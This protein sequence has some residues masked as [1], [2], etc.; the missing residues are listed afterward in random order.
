MSDLKHIEHSV[1]AE[2]A[3]LARSLDALSE[4][5]NPSAVAHD[6]STAAVDYGSELAGKALHKLRDNPAGGV[7]VALGLGLMASGSAQRR[8]QPTPRMPTANAPE[9]ALVGMDERIAQADADMR[10]E[11][12]SQA[13]ASSLQQAL[14][15]GLDGLPPAA[16]KRVI[17]A[18]EAAIAA[19]RSVEK[20]SKRA[21]R[22]TKSFA[23]EQP[24]ALGALALG[25][26]VIAGSLLPGT[27]REDEVLGKRRDALVAAARSTLEEEMA[28]ARDNAEELIER[29][30]A[31]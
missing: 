10:A 29:K 5:V 30:T 16:K 28:K 26:G 4:T 7:L 25:F 24:L 1:E 3:Q 13:D 17:K 14:Q 6:V 15:S 23:Y 19:Q 2:R 11:Y 20:H 27:R 18:R 9:A 8:R 12:G 22:K 31:R 21:V